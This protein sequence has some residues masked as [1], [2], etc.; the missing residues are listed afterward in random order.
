VVVAV[1]GHQ[2]HKVS[3]ESLENQVHKALRGL[4]G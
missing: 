1:V 4:L 2:D 3:R